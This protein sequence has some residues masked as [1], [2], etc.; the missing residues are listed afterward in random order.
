MA[1]RP[2]GFEYA[3][4]PVLWVSPAATLGL[5]SPFLDAPFPPAFEV[6]T[7][8]TT[9]GL[10]S[11]PCGANSRGADTWTWSGVKTHVRLKENLY[12]CILV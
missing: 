12:N 3:R 7:T 5:I 10:T 9:D 4:A 8:E 1:G 11:S 2:A 6:E